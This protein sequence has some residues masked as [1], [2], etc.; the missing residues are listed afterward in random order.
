MTIRARG[1]G[2]N[3]WK[4]LLWQTEYL[5]MKREG[6]EEDALLGGLYSTLEVSFSRHWWLGGRFDYVGLPTDTGN[7]LA[8][9]GIVVLALTEFSAVR[10]QYQ[11]QWLPEGPAVDSVAAQLNFTIGTHPAHNY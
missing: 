2:R 8:A 7:S 3:Q 10:L 9:T 11:H 4:R 5:W 1:H 6:A